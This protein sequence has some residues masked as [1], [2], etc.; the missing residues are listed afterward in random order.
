M[1][2][3]SPA[4]GSDAADNEAPLDGLTFETLLA[5][6]DAL[7]ATLDD[8]DLGLD[9]AVARYEAAAEIARHGLD[10]LQHAEARVQHL[11]LQ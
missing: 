3:S 11:S 6:L 4:P 7:A 10:R 8:P 1:S 2:T 5:R 9:D